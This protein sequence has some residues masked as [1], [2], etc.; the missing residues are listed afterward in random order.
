MS[1]GVWAMLQRIFGGFGAEPANE[2]IQVVEPTQIKDWMDAGEVVLVDVREADEY[3]AE[4]I[5]GSHFMALSAFDPARI[6]ELGQ[7]KLVIHCRSGVRC[8]MAANRLLESGWQGKIYRMKGGIIGW[9]A[10][11]C[12]VAPKR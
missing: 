12:E 2:Q 4:N 5:P 1:I 11:G 9:K 10:A 3:A 6:P 7:K 8:G